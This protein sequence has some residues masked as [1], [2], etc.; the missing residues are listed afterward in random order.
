MPKILTV[1]PKVVRQPGVLKTK[2]IPLNQYKSDITAEV[3]KHG[4]EKLVRIFHTMA[5]I[6][7]F[8]S[9]LNLVKTQGGYNGV[10][11]NHKGPAHLSMGQEAA[12]PVSRSR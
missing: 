4:K 1:D 10:D 11:Y 12:L 9:M 3:K 6:R 8:E 2:D 7:E 5:T